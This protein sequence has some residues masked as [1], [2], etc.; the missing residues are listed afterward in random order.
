MSDS[1]YFPVFTGILTK[2]HVEKIGPAVWEFL[3]LIAKTTKEVTED[4]ETIGIVLGGQP[5]KN[6]EIAE[7]LG[8]SLAKVERNISIL[9]KHGYV[10]TKR[11]PYGNIFKVK[12]SKKFYKNEIKK[13][14]TLKYEGTERS[15]PSNMDREPS[16]MTERT[17]KYEGNKEDIK[18]IKDINNTRQ[19]KYDEDNT[20]FKMAKYFYDKVEVVANEAG[21][22]HLIKKSNLQTWA[23]DMRKLIELDGVDKHLAK[24]VMDWVTQDSFWRT[25]VLSAKK[26]R[27]K[28]TELAIKMNADKK[29][30]Q[31]KQ[32][33]Q[34][35][36]RDK[37]IAF[38]QW[39]QGGNNPDDFDWSN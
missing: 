26:L 11:T 24:Q 20:Y 18:D 31:P 37:E 3:W 30:V 34:Y 1:F 9:R 21:V 8:Y 17:L 32:K 4:G 10:I 12:K 15:E 14:R 28:F 35:D 38:Q 6:I 33:L 36:P 7:S 39:V 25:N 16:N 19:K 29:P 23:D 22:S 13:K 2:E 5:I 27:E